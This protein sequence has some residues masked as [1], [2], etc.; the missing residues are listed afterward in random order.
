MNW[1]ARVKQFRTVEAK[2]QKAKKLAEQAE[3]AYKQERKAL[4]VSIAEEKGAT[5]EDP[6]IVIDG[7]QLGQGW[8]SS[9]KVI[10]PQICVEILVKA[11]HL[12]LLNPKVGDVRT[13]LDTGVFKPAVAERVSRLL[14]DVPVEYLV[15]RKV[16]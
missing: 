13:A 4:L 7:R 12:D 11:K 3:A 10:D 14:V 5:G 1:K 16:G 8:K 6:F 9:W 15:D 2:Y